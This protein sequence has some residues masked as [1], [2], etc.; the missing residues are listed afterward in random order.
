MDQLLRRKKR[1]LWANRS[2]TMLLVTA[3][4]IVL[5]LFAHRY[6][7]RADWTNGQFTLSEQTLKILASLEEPITITAFFQKN[8]PDLD[9]FQTLIDAYRYQS[10]QLRVKIVDP[11]RHPALVQEYGIREYGTLYL[12]RGEAH[13]QVTESTE[14]A[15]TNALIQLIE[16]KK[17]KIRVLAGHGERSIHDTEKE[18]LS[19]A[20]GALSGGHYDVEEL[21]LLKEGAIPEDTDL[22]VIMST[23]GPL[24]PQ[25]E[26]LVR[27][28]LN[29][30]RARALFCLDPKPRKSNDAIAPLLGAL[31]VRTDGSTIVDPM[32]RLFGADVAIPVVST[33]APH[34]IT[35]G[36]TM[37]T[38][39]PLAQPL[40]FEQGDDSVQITALASTQP[41]AWGERGPLTGEVD[42]TEGVDSQGP[43]A[44]A[45]A[46]EAGDR[47]IVIVGDA[48]FAS[49]A[50]YDFSGNGDLLQNMVHWLASE[51]SL[52]AIHPK[53]KTTGELRLTPIQAQW[54]FLGMVLV[55]LGFVGIA[56]LLWRRRRRQ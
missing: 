3:L 32:S 36:F 11:D 2:L 17:K 28:Y 16:G 10:D 30:D 33:Y 4:A 42:Y 24:L 26:K 40:F 8:S 50:Y 29:S 46:V 6:R 1:L 19:I 27:E 52:I 9:R 51:E 23:D 34:P 15:V 7:Y 41:S 56:V 12:E 5:V 38:F 47:R 43:L 31:A 18:G 20:A 22:L 45:L 14:E 35:R 55:P 21:V 54:L 39:F 13:V 25:E 44:V 53:E 37:A 48:D 49:N